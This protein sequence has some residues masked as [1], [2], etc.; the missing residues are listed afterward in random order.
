MTPFIFDVPMLPSN[1]AQNPDMSFN[2]DAF[3]SLRVI[4]PLSKTALSESEGAKH[5][6]PFHVCASKQKK[7]HCVVSPKQEN[8]DVKIRVQKSLSLPILSEPQTAAESNVAKPPIRKR[9]PFPVVKQNSSQDFR[10]E[11]NL[12]LSL[13]RA[14]KGVTTYN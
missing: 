9:R 5:G 6:R 13:R 3:V 4:E 14:K 11:T 12:R 8:E 1:V 7:G 2:S 10:S